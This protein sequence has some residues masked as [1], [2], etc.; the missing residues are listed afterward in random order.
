VTSDRGHD[1]TGTRVADVSDGG[2][3]RRRY[4]ER[5]RRRFERERRRFESGLVIGD[6]RTCAINAV[7]QYTTNVPP[8]Q[9]TNYFAINKH[10]KRPCQPSKAF[11]CDIALSSL[12]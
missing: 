10:H 9:G 11:R 5:E 6:V 2:K 7:G 1:E 4:F 3:E 8:F 12:L